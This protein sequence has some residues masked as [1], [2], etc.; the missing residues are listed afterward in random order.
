[1]IAV[2]A[3]MSFHCDAT[4]T[5][6]VYDYG[7]KRTPILNL[8]IDGCTLSLSVFDSVPLADHLVFARRL[9]DA[10]ARYLELLETYADVNPSAAKAG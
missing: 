5:V 3:S 2:P 6:R 7:T 9:A 4:T 10:T 8:D 1:M